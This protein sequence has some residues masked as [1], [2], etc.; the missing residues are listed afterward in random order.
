METGNRPRRWC[1]ERDGS[2]LLNTSLDA[3]ILPVSQIWTPT[4][5]NGVNLDIP[6]GG[7]FWRAQERQI[8]VSAV[9]ALATSMD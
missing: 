2:I 9:F 3:A 4:W 1:R 7:L 6:P 8:S 5:E